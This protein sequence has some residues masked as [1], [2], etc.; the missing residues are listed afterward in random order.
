MCVWETSITLYLWEQHENSPSQRLRIRLITHQSSCE[1]SA[2]V[3]HWRERGRTG[4]NPEGEGICWAVLTAPFFSFPAPSASLSL[5]LSLTQSALSSPTAAGC[6]LGK[7]EKNLSL[8][9]FQPFLSPHIHSFSLSLLP[10][11]A[12]L[13]SHPPFPYIYTVLL[14]LLS[15]RVCMCVCSYK[16]FHSPPQTKLDMHKNKNLICVSLLVRSLP[17]IS[18]QYSQMAVTGYTA[19]NQP[20]QHF[21]R[22]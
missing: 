19:Y 11:C 13:V 8:S 2:A 22:Y 4:D 6:F 7:A 20:K 15:V 9:L 18:N 21:L 16:W 14:P 17:F 1:F 10:S 3:T 5:L 12:L